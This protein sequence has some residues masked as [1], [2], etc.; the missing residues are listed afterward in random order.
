MAYKQSTENELLEARLADAI[1]K[2]RKGHIAHLPFLT[3]GEHRRAERFL[4]SAGAYGQAWFWGGYPDAERVC[5]FLLPEY[6][7]DML[8]AA[9]ADC[10][11]EELAAFLEESLRE[12]VCAVRIKGSGFRTLSHRD[13]LGAV[14]GLGISRDAVGDLAVQDS[15]TAVLF[16]SRT[17]ADFFVTDLVKVGADT[18]KCT[19]YVPDE[20]FTDGRRYAP[21]SD[22]VASARLDCAVAALCNLSRDAAQGLIRTGMVEVEYETAERTDLVLFPPVTITV[23]G[24][25]KFILRSFDGETH[26]GRLRLRADKLI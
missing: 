23:R 18:V 10:P 26:K 5:L 9:P 14:L 20:H 1:E 21:I 8:S 11:L 6:L 12:C 3:P 13:F 22:T 15:F 16:C 19:L 2:S 25:G 17:L 7:S 4:K 24:H